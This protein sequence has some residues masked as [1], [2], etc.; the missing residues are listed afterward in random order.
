MGVVGRISSLGSIMLPWSDKG[1]LGPVLPFES[2]GSMIFTLMP[3][4]PCL[5]ST[6]HTA[7]SV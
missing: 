4:T 7:V 5:R 1:F 3:S 6:W 2:Q